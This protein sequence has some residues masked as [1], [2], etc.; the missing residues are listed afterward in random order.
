MAGTSIRLNAST[1]ARA[2]CFCGESGIV[3]WVVWD[4]DSLCG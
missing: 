3:S 1:R 2:V 4:L